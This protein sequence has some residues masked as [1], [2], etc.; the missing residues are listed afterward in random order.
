MKTPGGLAAI[1]QR[2]KARSQSSSLPDSASDSSE[3]KDKGA[4][5]EAVLWTRWMLSLL[6]I[7]ADALLWGVGVF[8]AEYGLN[9]ARFTAALDH[10]DVESDLADL[11]VASAVRCFF[12]LF[13]LV[14][15]RNDERRSAV[16][17][18]FSYWSVA[19]SAIAVVCKCI[20][21]AEWGNRVAPSVLLAL[22]VPLTLAQFYAQTGLQRPLRPGEG[23][24]VTAEEVAAKAERARANAA[25]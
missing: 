11:M 15:L 22:A 6:L 23:D 18:F 13:N 2:R 7:I 24:P 9:W 16:L 8:A 3:K 1:I 14:T 20:L 25:A 10:Y 21:Y 12:V 5:R 19:L 4:A 17:S